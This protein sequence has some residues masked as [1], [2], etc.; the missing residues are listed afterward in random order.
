MNVQAKFTAAMRKLAEARDLDL[1]V[2]LDYPNSGFLSFQPRGSFQAVL[3]F[4]FSFRT[5]R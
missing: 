5:G 4:P 3:R 2:E 1:L